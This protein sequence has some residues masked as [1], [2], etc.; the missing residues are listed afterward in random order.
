MGGKKMKK[1]M[2]IVNIICI[3]LVLSLPLHSLCAVEQEQF[4]EITINIS[5][6]SSLTQHK[7]KFSKEDCESLDQIFNMLKQ[8]FTKVS[9]KNETIVIFNDALEELDKL[10]LFGN[11]DVEELKMIMSE[12]MLLKPYSITGE[13]TNT[14]FIGPGFRQ[15][16][17]LENLNNKLFRLRLRLD[18]GI[19]YYIISTIQL[20]LKLYNGIIL[21][22]NWASFPLV[23][24]LPFHLHGT[25]ALGIYY[26]PALEGHKDPTPAKGWL[27]VQLNN[28]KVQ[29]YTGN[30]FGDLGEMSA[31]F[32]PW[33]WYQ[34]EHQ[35]G[36]D[37]FIGLSINKGD[38][39]YYMGSASRFGIKS[40]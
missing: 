28:N 23:N 34:E 33:V 7:T 24:I 10:G 3:F 31:V 13:T 35:I 19:L 20:I 30:I 8:R 11:I 29:N 36:I 40:N 16:E 39:L 15:H 6:I 25:I 9:N 1:T 4:E 22:T 14:V 27:E 18:E 2:Q 12:M 17:F 32:K 38:S 26:T 37:G 21:I 5:S